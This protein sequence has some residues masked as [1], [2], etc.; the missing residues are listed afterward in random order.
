MKRLFVVVLLLFAGLAQAQI[1]LQPGTTVSVTCPTGV[2]PVP[3]PPPNPNPTPAPPNPVPAPGDP[4]AQFINNFLLY[5]YCQQRGATPAQPSPTGPS[6]PAITDLGWTA[7]NVIR[8]K[9]PTAVYNVTPSATWLAAENA[10]WALPEAQR[11]VT[12]RPFYSVTVA[13]TAIPRPAKTA[14]TL[15]GWRVVGGHIHHSVRTDDP[16][17]PRVTGNFQVRVELLNED[18]SPSSGTGM[19]VQQQHTPN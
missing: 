9:V 5:S 14:I 13:E 15:L 11:R 6:Q 18:G 16:N 12:R 4:C 1:I 8:Q 10:Y 2:V 7:G 3:V 19:A 17:F